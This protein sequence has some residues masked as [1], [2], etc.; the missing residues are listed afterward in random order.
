MEIT[1]FKIDSIV[2]EFEKMRKI[3]IYEIY[4]ENVIK[5]D[6]SQYDFFPSYENDVDMVERKLVELN[7]LQ[8]CYSNINVKKYVPLFWVIRLY[9]DNLVQLHSYQYGCD[10]MNKYNHYNDDKN[11]LL[12]SFAEHNSKF[13]INYLDEHNLSLKSILKK[14]GFDYE[15]LKIIVHSKQND[16]H[17]DDII[18]TGENLIL[19]K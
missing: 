8:L 16:I 17:Y 19:I 1:Q 12:L 11:K 4:S 5:F 9:L 10:F 3:P 6:V 2:Y 7:K 15:N 14:Y 18:Q 13:K